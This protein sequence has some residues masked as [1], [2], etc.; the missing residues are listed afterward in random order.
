MNNFEIC[1]I[2]G[3]ANTKTWAQVHV[4]QP[5]EEE[6]E[7]EF[8]SLFAV[9]SLEARD[10][11]ESSLLEITAFGKEILTRFHELYYSAEELFSCQERLEK[12]FK[13]LQEEFKERV[14]LAGIAAVVLPQEE[15][16]VLYLTRLGKAQA[17]FW[18]GDQKAVLL[19]AGENEALNSVSGW[20][21]EGDVFALGTET[22]FKLIPQGSFRAT[23]SL[24]SFE[25]AKQVLAPIVHGHKE[26]SLAAL[27]MVRFRAS[28]DSGERMVDESEEVEEK[29]AAKIV[30]RESLLGRIKN[31]IVTVAA[32]IIPGRRLRQFV[33]KGVSRDGTE[34]IKL[35]ESLVGIKKSRR[36]AISV[37][38]LFLILLVVSVGFGFRKRSSVSQDQQETQLLESVNYNLEQAQQLTELNPIRAKSLLV[39]AQEAIKQYQEANAG[40]ESET[41]KA[42]EEKITTELAKISREYLINN[43]EVFFDLSLIK[44]DFKAQSWGLTDEEVVILA[45][46][47]VATLDLD[48]KQTRVIA[49]EEEA[50]EARFI[51]SV[52]AWAILATDKDLL[53]VDKNK[54]RVIDTRKLEKVKVTDLVGY[55]GNAY[56]LDKE[57]NQVWRY[58]GLSDGLAG[59]KEYIQGKPDLKDTVSLA[60]DGSVWI[61][62]NDGSIVKYTGGKQDAFALIGLDKPFAEPIR[63]FTDENQEFLYVLDRRN[64]KVVVIGKSGEYRAQYVWPGI[65]GV[66]DILASEKLGKI[67]LLTEGK[68][69]SL[70][71]RQ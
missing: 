10:Q 11:S 33:P 60:I 50:G 25:Q 59:G 36:M 15:K 67:F 9:F 17:Y 47:S 24:E 7:K 27:V 58:A 41:V 2:I 44:E 66:K 64:T 1:K 53:V 29:R 23:L 12:V 48:K 70:E 34:T 14:E 63:L 38:I 42:I 21:V 51:G 16:K 4:F 18:R 65:A 68:I 19:P 32:R 54:Q 62:F 31:R 40:K 45:K 30:L 49:G 46:D 71:I 3:S 43:A 37:G 20:F 57:N 61:M 69:Y 35:K 56:I 52:S 8:G 13:I 26:N 22:V 5:T 28:Q 55:A 6:K 39:E